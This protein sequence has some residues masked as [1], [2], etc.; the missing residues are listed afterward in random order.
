MTVTEDSRDLD[1]LSLAR[2]LRIGSPS[3]QCDAA[4]PITSKSLRMR[5]PKRP[6]KQSLFDIPNILG[7][8]VEG[9]IVH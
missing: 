6:F 1:T 3:G 9:S 8:M 2:G 5:L 7:Q 4:Y